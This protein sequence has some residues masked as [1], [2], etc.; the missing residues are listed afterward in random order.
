MEGGNKNHLIQ[1]GCSLGCSFIVYWKALQRI[2]WFTVMDFLPFSFSSQIA[3]PFCLCLHFGKMKLNEVW[4]E[5]W[6][7]VAVFSF[8]V[9]TLFHPCQTPCGQSGPVRSLQSRHETCSPH[10][11]AGVIQ[12]N[13]AGVC[14]WFQINL[15]LLCM[16][17]RPVPQTPFALQIRS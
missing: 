10:V 16:K 7:F 4:R 12:I 9:A 6:A 2:L 8:R 3:R 14:V 11:Y 1:H 13:T 5:S 17:A 15:Y